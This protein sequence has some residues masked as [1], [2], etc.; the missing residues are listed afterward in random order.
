[1][2]IDIEGGEEVLEEGDR[3]LDL[4]LRRVPAV[5][6]PGRICS[7]PEAGRGRRVVIGKDEIEGMLATQ[8]LACH[9]ATMECFRRAMMG[10]QSFEGRTMN[11]GHATKLSRTYAMLVEALS[12]HRGKAQQKVVVEHVT[13][14]AGGQAIVGNVEAPGGGSQGKSKDQ[15]HA[16]THAPSPALQGTIEAERETVPVAS[17][18]RA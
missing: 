12:R 5:Y 17:G 1:M 2:R 3:A 7:L 6:A 16:I 15:L 9:N 11:L 8:M 4:R 14:N 18:G 10:G 13:V